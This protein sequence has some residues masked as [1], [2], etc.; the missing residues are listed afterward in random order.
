M[1]TFK[2]DNYYLDLEK[3]CGLKSKEEK[4]RIHN[5]YTDMLHSAHDNRDGVAKSLFHTLYNNGYL[6]EVREEKIDKVLS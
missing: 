6:K 5:Y 4:Q 2:I 1:S 3:V